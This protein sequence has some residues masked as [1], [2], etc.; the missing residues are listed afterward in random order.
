MFRLCLPKIPF[1]SFHE[2]KIV[3]FALKLAT[4]SIRQGHSTYGYGAIPRP[5]Q[6]LLYS[7]SAAGSRSRTPPR[8]AS[9]L[10]ILAPEGAHDGG[11]KSP[12]TTVPIPLSIRCH[13]H[14]RPLCFQL[15]RQFPRSRRSG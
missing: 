8:A 13:F 7:P 2:F 3:T 10:T 1:S 11:W 9:A 5:Y 4:I 6:S 12:S 14:L 15:P